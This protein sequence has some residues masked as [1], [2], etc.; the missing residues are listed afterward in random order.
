MGWFWSVYA[1][2]FQFW[3]VWKWIFVSKI[4]VSDR[5]DFIRN[6][7]CLCVYFLLFWEKTIAVLGSNFNFFHLKNIFG[8]FRFGFPSE[9]IKSFPPNSEKENWKLC[10]WIKSKDRIEFVEL[11]NNCC[12]R[13][14]GRTV[15][16]KTTQKKIDNLQTRILKEHHFSLPHQEKFFD[17]WDCFCSSPLPRTLLRTLYLFLENH[18]EKYVPHLYIYIFMLWNA[19]LNLFSGDF[20]QYLFFIVYN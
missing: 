19:C 12:S 15:K 16:E 18:P 10:K 9:L 17:W 8:Q 14:L 2:F 6:L 4:S 3:I 1:A 13:N 7:I 20:M 5:F 11:K